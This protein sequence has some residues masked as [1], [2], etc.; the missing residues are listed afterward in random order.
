MLKVD[1]WNRKDVKCRINIKKTNPTPKSI[2]HKKP[3][4]K[5][6]SFN[7]ANIPTSIRYIP[8]VYSNIVRFVWVI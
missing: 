1:F 8:P 6:E 2:T 7:N 5:S 4:N 3:I